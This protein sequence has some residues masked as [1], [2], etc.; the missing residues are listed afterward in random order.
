MQL[1][2]Q[3]FPQQKMYLMSLPGLMDYTT[4]NEIYVNLNVNMEIS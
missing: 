4:A 2:D 3:R 1:C